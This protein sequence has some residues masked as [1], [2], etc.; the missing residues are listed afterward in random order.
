MLE[1]RTAVS[2][3]VHDADIARITL[4]THDTPDPSADVFRFLAKESIPADMTTVSSAPDGGFSLG[5]TVRRSHAADVGRS[6]S[7]LMAPRPHGVEVEDQVAKVSIVGQGLLSRP[8]YASRML[9]SLVGSGISA[10][11]LTASQLRVSVTVPRSDAVRAVGLLHSEFGLG[12]EA[13]AVPAS[14]TPRP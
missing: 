14:L 2:A 11:S 13:G 8:E 4:R 12:A 10:R 7:D 6:F 1:D 3:V 9:A 5:F